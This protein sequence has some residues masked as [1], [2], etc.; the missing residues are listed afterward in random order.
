MARRTAMFSLLPSVK[1]DWLKALRSGKY[2]QTQNT[3]YDPHSK[4]FCC[5]G[6][7]CEVTG[8]KRKNLGYRSMPQSAGVFEDVTP[9]GDEIPKSLRSFDNKEAAWS[10]LYNGKMTPLSVLN[11]SKG[12]NFKQIADIIE[13]RVPTHR[14]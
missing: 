14:G 13:K 2:K 4:G 6:V 8:T 9:E 3:L 7:L 12:L 1:R 11:D 5:L 10:V